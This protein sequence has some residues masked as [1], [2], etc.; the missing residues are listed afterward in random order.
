MTDVATLYPFS[1]R[2]LERLRA[3]PPQGQTHRWFSQVAAGLVGVF[4]AQQCF[5]FLR[6]CCDELVTHRSVPDREIQAAIEFAYSGTGSPLNF[7]RKALSW[8]EP[9]A[10]LIA[11]TLAT[12]PPAFADAGTDGPG[13]DQVLAALFEPGE[14]VCTGRN[15]ERAMVRPIEDTVADADW[16]QFI[17]VNPMRD[18]EAPNYQGKLAARCQ[19]N[20][21]LR[22]HLVAEFDNPAL[23][24]EQQARLSTKLGQLAPL[25]LVVDSGGKSLHA[26]FRVDHLS[27]QDQ[28]RFFCVA[29][30]LGA[31]A[32]RWDVC[33]WLRMPGGLRVVDGVPA[34]RQRILHFEP[35][36][37]RV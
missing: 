24:K 7:G 13:A 37:A 28:V 14:L 9:S 16:L 19:N 10:A 20:T 18:R 36:A 12:T 29:C 35:K 17:V 26:W 27:R 2:T 5:R 8:P 31:D 11:K 22:R 6:R 33:G 1:N 30:L 4:T 3:M 32:T 25:V 34:T 15:T 23:S 21:G